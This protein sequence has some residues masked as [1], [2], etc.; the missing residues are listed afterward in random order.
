[1]KVSDKDSVDANPESVD[2]DPDK[3]TECE[4]SPCLYYS[5]GGDIWQFYTHYNLNA[6]ATNKQK[7]HWAYRYAY[8]YLS[9]RYEPGERVELPSCVT[10]AIREFWP[11]YD[12]NYVGYVPRKRGRRY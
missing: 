2:A 11:E 7:R 6:N 10:N 5:L 4:S 9:D 1:M 3:C 8:T 12:G